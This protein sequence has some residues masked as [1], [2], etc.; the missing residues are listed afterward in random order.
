MKNCFYRQWGTF[1][2]IALVLLNAGQYTKRILV[3]KVV[4]DPEEPGA[5]MLGA[6]SF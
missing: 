2:Y 3:V 1:G 4:P 5:F 6:S